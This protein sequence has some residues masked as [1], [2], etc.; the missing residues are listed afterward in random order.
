VGVG[1]GTVCERKVD[2]LVV[3][4]AFVIEPRVHRVKH[5]LGGSREMPII[6]G[7]RVESNNFPNGLG[8]KLI[9]CRRELAFPDEGLTW[10]D[11]GCPPPPI[12]KRRG[13]MLFYDSS[14]FFLYIQIF[15]LF[16]NMNFGPWG[17]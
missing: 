9:M 7:L 12:H 5:G 6:M 2:M 17:I 16:I 15:N 8:E 4:F 14:F 1:R 10:L 13:F 3:V 11:E